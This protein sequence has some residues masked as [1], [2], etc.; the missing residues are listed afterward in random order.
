MGVSIRADSESRN[1]AELV[2]EQGSSILFQ[3]K[4]QTTYACAIELEKTVILT[5]GEYTMNRVSIYSI[6]G[7]ERNLPNLLTGRRGHG[8]GQYIDSNNIQVTLL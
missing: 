5:G 4:Y 8:C 7:F 1:T 2:T 3:M 6:Q